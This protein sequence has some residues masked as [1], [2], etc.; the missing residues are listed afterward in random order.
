[1]ELKFLLTSSWL[2]YYSSDE[3]K[4]SDHKEQDVLVFRQI[5]LTSSIRNVWRTVRRVC[6]FMSGL[7]GLKCAQL[8][9]SLRAGSLSVLF[10]QVSW[11]RESASEAGRRMEARTSEPSRKPLNFEIRLNCQGIKYLTNTS[12]AKCKQMWQ[13]IFT[14]K[15]IEFPISQEK[16]INTVDNFCRF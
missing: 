1:M 4:G 16:I 7:K 12:E 2:V 15:W 13:Q 11:Q 6:I 8:Q 14:L 9:D 3:N 5:L 10:T